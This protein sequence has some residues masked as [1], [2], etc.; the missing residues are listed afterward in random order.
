MTTLPS[1]CEQHR[2]L[3]LLDAAAARRLDE[4]AAADA[5]QLAGALGFD[6]RRAREAVPVRRFL[7]LGEQAGKIAAVESGAGRRA[8]GHLRLLDQIAAAQLERIDLELGGRLV[9]Q[10]LDDVI[11]F[12]PAGAAIG[13]GRR[14]C[15]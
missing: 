7:G 12:R 11:R 4:H 10:P 6:C 2:D 5:A 15:W 1:R 13:I 3:V 8:I 14:R 9:D